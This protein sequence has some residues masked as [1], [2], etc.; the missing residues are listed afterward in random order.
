MSGYMGLAKAQYQ[1]IVAK[2][3]AYTLTNKDNDKIFTNRGATGAVTFTLPT[4]SDLTDG[5]SA[6]FFVVA[7]QSVTIAS[8]EGDNVV[9]FNDAAAD[10]IAFSTSG[11][12]VGAGVEV[13]RDGTGWL[14]FVSLGMDSQ[15]PTIAT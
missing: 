5:W 12:K 4:A 1:T 15:T 13:V 14:A 9:A 7:D 11:E 10:S 3:A 6:R 8:A 2:T